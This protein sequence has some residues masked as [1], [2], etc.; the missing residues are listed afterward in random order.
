M[1]VPS[2]RNSFDLATCDGFHPAPAHD[3]IGN[4]ELEVGSYNLNTRELSILAA[5]IAGI[6]A[7]ISATVPRRTITPA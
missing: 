7:A 6:A 5:R 3:P 4:W 2:D 1:F